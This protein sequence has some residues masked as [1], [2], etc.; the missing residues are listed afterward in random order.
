MTDLQ[1]TASGLALLVLVAPLTVQL[2]VGWP[3]PYAAWNAVTGDYAYAADRLDPMNSQTPADDFARY[4]P[5]ELDGDG[6][7]TPSHGS[8]MVERLHVGDHTE[9]R[10]RHRAEPTSAPARQ[11]TAARKRA[12]RAM[13][14]LQVVGVVLIAALSVIGLD[15]V[16]EM[17]HH[18]RQPGCSLS[19]AAKH[20]VICAPLVDP[21]TIGPRP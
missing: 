11:R 4:F 12:D 15:A 19:P 14:A 3:P 1:L 17:A 7:Q 9:G 6:E 2:F 13:D 8:N 16:G 18:A 21:T 5:L 10:G 20:H